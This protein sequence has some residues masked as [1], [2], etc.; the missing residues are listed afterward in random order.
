VTV[1]WTAIH[2]TAQL[3]HGKTRYIDAGSGP[4]L[5]LLH[6]S[7]IES[8]ADDCLATLGTLAPVFRVL[9]PD[10][11]GF[12]PS[13]TLDGI[14]AFPFLVDFLREFQDALGISR[15]H[16]V[17]VSMGGWI[18]GLFAYESPD[19]CDKVIIGGHPFTGAPNRGMLN[20][21]VDSVTPDA[22][23]R[24]W[25]EKR[26]V[27]HGVDT[28]ALV[29]EKLNKI[30]EPGFAESFTKLM[31]SMGN[32]TNRRRYAT[33]GRLPHLRVPALILLGE[34]DEAAMQ[35]KDQVVAAAPT[36]ELR[37]VP[38]GHRMHIEDPELF[39]NTVREYLLGYAGR[40]SQ[41]IPS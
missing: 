7:S 12:P 20:F 41:T 2:K 24:D 36:A 18:A 21:T 5:I 1:T 31:L 37:V 25:V 9:A 39:A 13:D 15:S 10:L 8:G 30:H 6:L 35:L 3:K 28:E 14:D 16:V 32:L 29:H 19:R 34:R 40:G 17:G 22:K 11:L 26:T 27:G 4:P 33:I 23:V 38:S